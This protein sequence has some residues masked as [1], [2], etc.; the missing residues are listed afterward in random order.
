MGGINTSVI[1]RVRVSDRNVKTF[2][3]RGTV[4]SVRV[5]DGYVYVAGKVDSIE[6]VWRLRIVSADSA[7]PAEQFYQYAVNTPSVYAVTFSDDGSMY[8]GTGGP[9][10][11]YVVSPGGTAQPL[12]EPLLKPDI[13]GLAWGKGADLYVAR[14]GTVNDHIIARVNTRKTGAPYFGRQ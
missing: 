10:G 11:V 14:G 12:Y 13:T 2:P 6:G 8:L 5:Y 1:S 7:A 9:G 3:F 4:R